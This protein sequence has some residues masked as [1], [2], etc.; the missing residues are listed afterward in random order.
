MELSFKQ[1]AYSE[2]EKVWVGITDNG[3]VYYKV[4]AIRGSGGWR[5][6]V[7]TEDEGKVDTSQRI[8]V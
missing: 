1:V 4:G 7:S 2:S 6:A 3:E 5:R 8:R